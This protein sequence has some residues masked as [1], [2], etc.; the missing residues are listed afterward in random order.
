M[1]RRSADPHKPAVPVVYAL[2]ALSVVAERGL[3]RDQL[4]AGTGISPAALENPEARLSVAQYGRLIEKALQLTGDPGLGYELG[5]RSQLTK[6]GFLGYGLMSCATLRE[7]IGLL[8]RYLRARTPFFDMRLST[9]TR[10]AIIE[11]QEALAFGRLRRFGFDAFLV[12]LGTLFGSLLGEP[13]PGL[14]LWFDYPQPP[15]VR[16]YRQ[17]LPKLRFS[18][19]ANQLRFPQAILD[20]K[21]VTANPVTARLMIQECERELSLLGQTGDFLGQVRALLMVQSR[22]PGGYPDPAAVSARLN[23]SGRS[24]KRKLRQHGTSYLELLAQT[25]LRDS[26]RLLENLALPVAEVATRVGYSDPANFTRAFRQWTGLTPSS[27][28]LRS[29]R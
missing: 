28:R 1:N 4:L 3:G 16:R 11:V 18:R 20:R 27:Y 13:I 8:I 14:E 7:A 10:H 29:L 12:E 25:R 23:M 26:R 24:L 2:F 19:A 17:R 9:D 21:L 5:L 22:G 6:H 15:N